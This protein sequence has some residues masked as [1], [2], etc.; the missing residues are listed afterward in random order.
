MLRC[1]AARAQGPQA[2]RHDLILRVIAKLLIPF[3]LLFA[4]YVQ[5]HGDFGPRR[6][7]PGRRDLA[8]AVS[9]TR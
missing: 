8:A 5:F 6:R 9:S 4:L 1:C 3:I 2:M 7:L